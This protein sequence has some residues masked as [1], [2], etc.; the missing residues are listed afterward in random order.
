MQPQ[1]NMICSGKWMDL[2]SIMLS[3]LIQTQNSRNFM[4]SLMCT[5]IITAYVYVNKMTWAYYRQET[6]QEITQEWGKRQW[7]MTEAESKW[8]DALWHKTKNSVLVD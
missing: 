4:V 1:T 7:E 5:L 6:R 3:E 2:K 8:S